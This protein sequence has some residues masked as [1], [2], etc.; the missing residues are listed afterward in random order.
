MK[1]ALNRAVGAFTQ[2]PP[3]SRHLS[4][5]GYDAANRQAVEGTTLAFKSIHHVH[6]SD[7]LALRV[8]GVRDGVTDDVLQEDFEH[9]S[10]LLV[11]EP[12]D[13]FYA[14]STCQTPD[15]GLRD[16]LN[17]VTQN[18]PVTLGSS[19]SSPFPPLPRPDIV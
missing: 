4:T 1:V 15:G 13:A 11:D 18:L 7:G 16:A 5:I 17:I 3:Q 9:T 2:H 14:T 10:G 6:G 12:R 8:L 19:L